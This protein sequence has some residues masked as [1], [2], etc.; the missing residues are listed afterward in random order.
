[1]AF[2]SS[3]ATFALTQQLRFLGDLGW[4]DTGWQDVSCCTVERK[5]KSGIRI[6]PSAIDSALF[7]P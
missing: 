7:F 3:E 4:S 2:Q 6:H 1:M 5:V